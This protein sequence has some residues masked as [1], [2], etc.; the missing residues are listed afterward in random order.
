MQLLNT[1]YVTDHQARLRVKKH[2]L[3]VTTPEGE[4]RV[5]IETLDGVVLT[6]RADITNTA[7][8]DLTRRAVR[9]SAI[10]KTGKLRFV[11]TGPTAG[12][13]NLRLQ[14][15]RHA[16]DPGATLTLAR[17]IVA[18]KLQ[19]AA[20]RMARWST[21]TS[22]TARAVIDNELEGVRGH[23]PR[24]ASARDGD[25][26]RGHEGD[27]TRRYFKSMGIHLAHANAAFD[28]Q[29]RQRRPPRDPVNAALSYTYGL[30]LTETVG[31]LDA[32]GLDPQ[33]GFLHR[34]RPGRPGL[35]LDLLEEFRPSI[36]DRLVVRLFTRDQLG[37]QHFDCGPTGTTFLSDSGRRTLLHHYDELRN[38]DTTHIM[39][40]RSVPTGLL[41]TIQATLLARF[42]RGDLPAYPPYVTA[43]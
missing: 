24:L 23:L 31:A 19:N 34:P 42:L 27:G 13:V 8:G 22:S 32:V 5:P 26:L 17:L 9:V 4:Q 25:E 12:N 18:G 43:R 39:L 28:F 1:L 11:V 16:T 37:E 7:L 40:Q 38:T 14:Q 21:R 15:F 30:L 10:S 35:A 36:A 20:R 6:G 3:V 41:P 2:N 33:I 29:H